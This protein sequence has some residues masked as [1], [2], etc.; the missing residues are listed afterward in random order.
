MP[1][2][3]FKRWLEAVNAG[4]VDAVVDLYSDEA[5]V[6]PTFS[7]QSLNQP[8]QRRAYF[9]DLAHHKGLSVWVDETSL[10]VQTLSDHIASV[11]GIYGWHFEVKDQPLDF[12]ARF[13]FTIDPTR[14]HPILHHHSSQIPQKL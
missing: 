3:I 9:D 10:V 14:E 2:K 5:V 11:S 4:D 7:N 13:T 8:D 12:E 6:L 1:E